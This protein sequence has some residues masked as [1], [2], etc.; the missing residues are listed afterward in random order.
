MHP[1][2]VMSG[3]HSDCVMPSSDCVGIRIWPIWD[4]ILTVLGPNCGSVRT[5]ILNVSRPHSD[6]VGIPF[7]LCQDYILCLRT[8]LWPCR[9][10]HESCNS[11]F[12]VLQ[13]MNLPCVKAEFRKCGLHGRAEAA[14]PPSFAHTQHNHVPVCGGLIAVGSY[15]TAIG[16]SSTKFGHVRT[17]SLPLTVG[18]WPVKGRLRGSSLWTA[19]N[20]EKNWVLKDSPETIGAHTFEV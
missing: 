12:T 16:A 5:P 13:S 1:V 11:N 19:L 18:S 4:H 2:L 7:L 6:C 3:S 17:C 9:D 20:A 14:W 10:G 8:S 15:K